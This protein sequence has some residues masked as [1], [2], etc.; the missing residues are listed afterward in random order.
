MEG[1]Q[2]LI[3]FPR[4]DVTFA[5]VLKNPLFLVDIFIVLLIFYWIYRLLKNTRAVRIL[6]GVLIL[7]GMMYLSFF[8]HL[9][10][11]SWVLGLFLT[12]I[13]VAIPVVFQPEF[14]NALEKIGRTRLNASIIRSR[15]VKFPQSILEALEVMSTNK[16]GGLIAIQRKT[17]LG[18]YLKSGI[19]LD[20]K[21][22]K[23]LILACFLEGS[24]LHDG[25]LVIAG[26]R[27]LG[28]SCLFPLSGDE[29]AVPLGTRHK[30]AVGLTE[31]TDALCIV[32][33]GKNGQI[34]LAYEGKLLKNIAQEELA[35]KLKTLL[36][37]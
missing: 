27:I 25:A 37:R 36:P 12:V 20:S 5:D 30:A 22:S 2:K 7:A 21:I 13:L 26:N 6:F 19:E 15:N 4:L 11:L 33:S 29:S 1:I 14:R 16:I 17:G 34:S 28:A 18:D 8:L 9:T 3:N 23:N 35:K 31:E 24:P 10:L 32:V